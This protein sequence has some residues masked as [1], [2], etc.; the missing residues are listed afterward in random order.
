MLSPSIL[1]HFAAFTCPHCHEP[2][3]RFHAY[4]L[5][6]PAQ[7]ISSTSNLAP[8]HLTCAEE[9]HEQL[10]QAQPPEQP[11]RLSVI[12]VVK[13]SPQSPS[14]RLIRLH[15]EDPDT[16]TFLLFTPDTLHFLHQSLSISGKPLPTTANGS[17]SD[18]STTANSGAA[19]LITRP[20]TNA[21]VLQWMSPAI[22]AA[23][24]KAH[25]NPEEIKELTVT[26][27]RLQKLHIN[28]AAEKPARQASTLT[29]L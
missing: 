2:L 17:A 21:E 14:A 6:E 13:A 27:G 4:P 19:A 9:C 3:G 28:P 29:Q 12:A 24:L 8:M 26:L 5:L 11:S 7:V 18:P 10:L 23:M 15:P 16:T 1:A 25:G 22:E 20:A